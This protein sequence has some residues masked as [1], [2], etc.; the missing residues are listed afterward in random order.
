QNQAG[1]AAALITTSF[2]LGSALGLAVFSGLFSGIAASRTSHLLAAHTPP[3]GGTHRRIPTGPARQRFSSFRRGAFSSLND[4]D[5]TGPANWAVS[6]RPIRGPC[7]RLPGWR[8]SQ[9]GS[10]PGYRTG[11]QIMAKYVFSFRVPS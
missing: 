11:P 5:A 3:P 9:S 8:R 2:Q 1:L 6:A 4:K 7:W 10:R